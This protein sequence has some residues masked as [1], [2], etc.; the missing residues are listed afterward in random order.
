MKP[1]HLSMDCDLESPE[2]N[3]GCEVSVGRMGFR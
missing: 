3:Q 1:S 2:H